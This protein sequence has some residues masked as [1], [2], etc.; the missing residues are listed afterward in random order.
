MEFYGGTEMAI[1]QSGE[2]YLEAIL[3]LSGQT[4]MVRSI[5]V[6]AFLGVTKPS[7]SRAMTILKSDG[8][9]EMAADGALRLTEKGQNIASSMYERHKFLTQFL[10][11]LG[12]DEE[13][14]AEDACR[15]EHIISE[16]SFQ[17]LREHA[18][19][20]IKEKNGI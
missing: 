16:E 19:K 10:I 11:H 14:A 20:E 7:V 3:I 15:M 6:A 13:T 4:P 18:E 1:H 9:V 12:V 2:D 8:M 17:K 5:D